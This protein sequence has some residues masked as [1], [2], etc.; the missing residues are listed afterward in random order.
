MFFLSVYL[1][2]CRTAHQWTMAIV[3]YIDFLR[4]RVILETSKTLPLEMI[5]ISINHQDMFE[6]SFVWLFL[7]QTKQRG[8]NKGAVGYF[9]K[10]VEPLIL[11][12]LFDKMRITEY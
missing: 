10:S 8:I 5:L 7:N 9:H 11:N 2:I 6:R 4:Q 1:Q 12:V 3:F